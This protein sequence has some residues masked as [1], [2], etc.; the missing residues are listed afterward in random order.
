MR[1]V[2]L[3]VL[4]GLL[5]AA[6]CGSTPSF[7]LTIV[8]DGDGTITAAPGGTCTGPKTCPVINVS[9]STNILLSGS[10]AT[11]WVNKSWV[12]DVDGATVTLP[13]DPNGTVTVN[14]NKGSSA[15]VTV[16]FVTIGSETDAGGPG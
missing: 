15:T 8:I 1:P 3:A 10:P 9:P 14:G 5:G 13:V 12:L 6:G 16:T 11:G 7:A 2:H 4:A